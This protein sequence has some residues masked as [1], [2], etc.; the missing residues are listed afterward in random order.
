MKE[1]AAYDCLVAHGVKP[2]MQRMA[3]MAYL[4]EHPTHPTA[5]EIHRALV[6]RM[7]TLSKTTVYNTLRLL[8]EK[9]AAGM[10]TI[11]ERN[12]SFDGTTEPHG[13]FL[14]RQ[15]GRVYDIPAPTGL[16]EGAALVPQG[17]SVDTSSLYYRGLCAECRA[18]AANPETIAPQGA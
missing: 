18:A 16:L 4:L 1:D 2:S 10:L 17:F 14:C 5:D 8:V 6:G 7:P 3:V 9:H 11:D 15:C 12:V 13:H